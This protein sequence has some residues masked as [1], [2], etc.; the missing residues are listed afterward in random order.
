MNF[1]ESP[2][3]NMLV[4]TAIVGLVSFSIAIIVRLY[5]HLKEKRGSKNENKGKL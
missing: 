1:F 2:E 4:F 3:W 5:Y